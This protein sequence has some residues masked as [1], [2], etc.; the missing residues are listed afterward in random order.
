M[1]P[2]VDLDL[3]RLLRTLFAIFTRNLYIIQL[4]VHPVQTHSTAWNRSLLCTYRCIYTSI[5]LCFQALPGGGNSW[6]VGGHCC[7]ILGLLELPTPGPSQQVPLRVFPDGTTKG[8]GFSQIGRLSILSCSGT[9]YIVKRFLASGGTWILMA[10]LLSEWC[11]QESNLIGFD[12]FPS[13]S[14]GMSGNPWNGENRRGA[15][16]QVENV[17]TVGEEP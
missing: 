6:E 9:I 8:E 17:G 15:Q 12:F 14:R 10:R 11:V 1:P 16:T 3:H 2:L 13:N 5:H 7:R 4:S